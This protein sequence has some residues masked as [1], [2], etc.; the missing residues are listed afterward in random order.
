M[1]NDDNVDERAPL[2]LS[3][4]LS[5]A[6][7]AANSALP[8]GNAVVTVP[9]EE[10]PPYT[11]AEQN[12]GTPII[13]CRVCQTMINV[14]G[15]LH[16]HVVKCVSCNEA[17][18]IRNAPQHKKYV[19]C[20]CNCLLICKASSMRIACPRANCKR[21]ISLGP[22]N[23]IPSESVT[24]P[25]TNVETRVACGHCLQTFLFNPQ[26]Q[27]LARCPHCRRVSSVGNGLAA[28]RAW[29]F[30]FIGLACLIVAIGL[31]VGLYERAK[32]QNAYYFLWAVAY[33][34][35]IGNFC[36]AAH[37]AKMRISTAYN[38]PSANTV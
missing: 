19:R 33:V 15:K 14:E 12:S 23:G 37:Y 9:N 32:S 2:L 20:P 7:S 31:T 26:M 27:A 1:A 11:P 30:T 10:P 35:A 22:I 3:N 8:N 24:P 34:L 6:E 36:R 16:Q 17:T 4:T 28:R 29:I 25:T 5:S 21:I 38:N 18:P 13:N